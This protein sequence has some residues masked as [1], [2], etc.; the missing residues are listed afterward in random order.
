MA[1]Y[2]RQSLQ[3]MIRQMDTSGVSLKEYRKDCNIIK[4]LD[5]IKMAWEEVTV[6]CMKGMWHKIWPSNK[7][8]GINCDNLD[9]MVKEISEITEE[10]GLDIVDP[11]GITEVLESHSQPLSNEELCGLAQQMTEQQKEDEHERIV[12]PKKCKRRTLL[13]FFPLQIWQLRSYVISILP[14]N[15]ALH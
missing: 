8:C 3:E 6:S 11:V 10:F 12:E 4:A 15:A 13:I 1:Y 7:N 9:M 14:E 5:I 2:L